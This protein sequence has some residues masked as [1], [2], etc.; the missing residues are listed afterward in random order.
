DVVIA[1][2]Q[3]NYETLSDVDRAIFFILKIKCPV[4]ARDMGYSNGNCIVIK[5]NEGES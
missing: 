5:K 3:A 1:K 4:I 2:G